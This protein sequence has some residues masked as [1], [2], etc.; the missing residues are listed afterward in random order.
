MTD[1][2]MQC[3]QCNKKI[4]PKKSAHNIKF[5]SV[6]CRNKSYLPRVSAWQ[7]ARYD[8]LSAIPNK[9]KLQC[10]ICF[11]WYVQ[12]GSHINERHEMTAREYREQY[13]LPVKR[14]I[15]P[16]WYRD[17]KGQQALDNK[18]YKNLKAGKKY[19]YK[20]ND[21]RARAKNLYWKGKHYKSTNFYEV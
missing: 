21:K 4:K 7:R 10:A 11:H 20:K 9:K 5:C 15:T 2:K 1:K 13:G 3:K 6:R 12:V 19:W 14:G 8:R 17:K 16:K 18:T